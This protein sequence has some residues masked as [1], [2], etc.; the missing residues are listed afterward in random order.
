MRIFSLPFLMCFFIIV[1]SSSLFSQETPTTSFEDL[2]LTA[3]LNPKVEFEAKQLAEKLGLPISIYL[4]DGIFINALGIENGKPIYALITNL[5]HPFENGQ[6]VYFEHVA[7]VYDLSEARVNYGGGRIT[8][9]NLGYSSAS[10]T[11][12]TE[13][14]SFVMIP[15]WTAD[16]VLSFNAFNGDLINPNFIPSNN[17]NLQSPKAALLNKYGF[18]TVSD[19]ISDLVQ[20]YD[21]TG[22]YLGFFAPAGGVNTPILDNIRGHNYRPNG[23][24]VVCVGSGGNQNSIA[25]FDE[26]GNYLGQFIITSSGG[27]TS[28]FDIIFRENDVLVT[29]STSAG[30]YRYSSSGAFLNVLVSGMSFAQQIQELE[31]K[32]L[33]V[34]EF[35]GTGQGIRIY[36]SAGTFIKVLSGVTGNR[37]VYQLKNGNFLTT[38]SSGVHEVDSSSGALIRTIVSGVSAQYIHPF[39]SSMIIPVELVSF[40]AEVVNSQVQLTWITASEKNNRGFEIEKFSA[41]RWEK[42]GFVDGKGT[43]VNVSVYNFVDKDLEFGEFSYRLK[44]IDFDGTYNYSKVVSVLIELPSHFALEQNYPN[45]FNPSTTI[46]WQSPVGSHQ[47]LKV[48]DLLGREVA[49]LVNE[50]RDAGR[51]SIEFDASNLASGVYI[52]QLRVND[53]VAEKKLLLMK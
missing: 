25:E 4:P 28:P 5:A 49:T 37:G 52:Y 27:L 3:E 14:V 41:D 40:S 36:D 38:N 33:A 39:D 9:P 47:T 42:I 8:N 35:S 53:F 12:V 17:P 20:K 21:T 2:M 44:Q 31:D 6:V 24:L 7:A 18:I 48:F 32:R 15:D 34:A 51:Y 23:N 19:Q 50:W 43:T 26:S 13:A 1:F 30:V 11:S 10:T 45:P 22:A 29:T 46:S 16:K